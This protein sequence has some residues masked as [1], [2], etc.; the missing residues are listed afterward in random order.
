VTDIRNSGKDQPPYRKFK[1]GLRV[2]WL[3]VLALPVGLLAIGGGPC[4]GPRNAL[5]WA[6]LLTVGA[7]GIAGGTFGIITIS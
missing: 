1:T 6:I 4:A 3:S 2:C 7:V 5:G